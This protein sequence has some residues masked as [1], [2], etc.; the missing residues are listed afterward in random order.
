MSDTVTAFLAQNKV[1]NK[2][3]EVYVTDSFVSPVTGNPILWKIRALSADE[4]KMIAD[5][6]KLER[7]DRRTGTITLL[8]DDAE[9]MARMVAQCVEYPD[10]G[11]RELQTSY[12]VKNKVGAIRAMLTAG[13]LARLAQKIIKLSD[14]DIE[15]DEKSDFEMEIQHAKNV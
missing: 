9:Y 13:E 15:D 2:T 14:L 8:T 1:Q 12:G 10:L 7:K 11:D 5:S 3:E 4:E 6:C